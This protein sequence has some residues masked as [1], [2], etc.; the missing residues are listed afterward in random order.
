MGNKFLN[1]SSLLVEINFF[2]T[3]FLVESQKSWMTYEEES[4]AVYGFLE[5][6]GG[7]KKEVG[8]FL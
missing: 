5:G 6:R 3:E 8:H 1:S 7:I 2:K 4:K